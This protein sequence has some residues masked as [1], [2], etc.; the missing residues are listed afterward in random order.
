MNQD[1]NSR[2][3]G[4]IRNVSGNDG[5]M[6][7]VEWLKDWVEGGPE[8]VRLLK[9]SGSLGYSGRSKNSAI[10]WY[11]A[12]QKTFESD[13]DGVADVTFV[14]HSYKGGLKVVKIK[15]H[16][17]GLARVHFVEDLDCV[18]SVGLCIAMP[19]YICI[20][21]DW[22]FED[23]RLSSGVQRGCVCKSRD[24]LACQ[25]FPQLREEFACEASEGSVNEPGHVEV[26][27]PSS[28]LVINSVDAAAAANPVASVAVARPT[29]VR[30]TAPTAPTAVAASALYRMRTS[31]DD[32][33]SFSSSDSS[34]M[35]VW[36]PE[37]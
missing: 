21:L 29:V 1:R 14:R 35:D 6:A 17:L 3:V 24:F 36:E 31:R 28:V 33:S 18:W 23:Y 20:P 15:F 13:T 11:L 22:V 7:S 2:S 37:S 10:K 12:A 32:S 27:V 4:V 30:G 16:S 5:R 25:R 19:R 34:V 26:L 8:W 9:L